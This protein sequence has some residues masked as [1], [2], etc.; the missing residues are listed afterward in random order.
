MLVPPQNS[1]SNFG[2]SITF[3][4]T[5]NLFFVGAPDGNTFG[6]VYIYT[7]QTSSWSQTGV[8]QP[9][10]TNLNALFGFDISVSMGI[11]A[12][13]AKGDGPTS[14]G[15]AYLY[16]VA[17]QSSTVSTWTATA[18][19]TSRQSPSSESD[20][21]GASVL[22]SPS[23]SIVAVGATT[24][25]SVYIFTQDTQQAWTQSAMIFPPTTTVADDF[26]S[27][28]SIDDTDRLLFV[29]APG[30]LIDITCSISI[31][32]KTNKR[33]N[34]HKMQFSCFLLSKFLA[35]NGGQTYFYYNYVNQNGWSYQTSLQGQEDSLEQLFGTSVDIYGDSNVVVSAP[36]ENNAK[37]ALFFFSSIQV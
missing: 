21:F 35:D 4:S 36:G 1:Y 32:F 30:G 8:I 5:T 7:F 12:V 26:G 22:V 34:T 15:L 10:T 11:L 25:G 19:L 3:D 24:F 16:Q 37:G 13:G 29:G 14:D 27:S 6:L 9:N 20:R 31:L 17:S 23:G 28:I 18:V 33:T 2:I